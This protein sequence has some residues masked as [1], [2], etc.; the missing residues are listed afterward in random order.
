MECKGHHRLRNVH[1]TCDLIETLWN[2]KD[3]CFRRSDNDV[4]DLIE[5]LWNVKQSV[6]VRRREMG[7][8]I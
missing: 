3:S 1:R 7:G 2:V 6:E 5:T 4:A 8:R